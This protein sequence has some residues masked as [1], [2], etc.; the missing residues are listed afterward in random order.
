MQLTMF[1][2][3]GLRLVMRLAAAEE[4]QRFTARGVAA[5]LN[6]SPAHV[7]KVVTRLGELGV[8]VATRGRGGGIRLAEGATGRSLGGLLRA[9]ETGEV[10]D[11]EAA[12]CPIIPFCR[13]RGVLAEAQEAFFAH[14]DG[15]TVDDLIV[16]EGGGAVPL[17]L[18]PSPRGR[19]R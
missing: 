4:G 15:L 17:T 19:I 16:R 10:I 18:S 12:E 13:L 9:L 2:D 7:A 6:A 1:S 5:E 3:L 11:C 8:L 14:L